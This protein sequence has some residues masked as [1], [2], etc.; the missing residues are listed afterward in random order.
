VLVEPDLMA[1]DPQA[2]LMS[3]IKKRGRFKGLNFSIDRI[4]VHFHRTG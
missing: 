1:Q 4:V 2:K 3:T